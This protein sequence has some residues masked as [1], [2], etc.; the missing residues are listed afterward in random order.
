MYLDIL[1][2]KGQESPILVFIALGHVTTQVNEKR[3]EETRH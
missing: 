2:T 3:A 1:L